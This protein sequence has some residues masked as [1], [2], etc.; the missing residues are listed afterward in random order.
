M[1][2]ISMNNVYLDH[3]GHRISIAQHRSD[4]PYRPH[5][6]QEIMIWKG[7]ED[8][9]DVIIPYSDTLEGLINALNKAKTLIEEKE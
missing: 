8:N 5:R 4:G 2:E 9:N 6:T 3:K 1:Q 7:D